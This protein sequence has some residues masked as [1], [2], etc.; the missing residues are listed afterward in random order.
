LQSHAG[1]IHLLPAIPKAWETGSF[2]GL[3]ARGGFELELNWKDGRVQRL[4]ITSATGNPVRILSP[5]NL[6]GPEVN[7]VQTLKGWE[8][9]METTAGSSYV[10]TAG[11]AAPI[12]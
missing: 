2:K 8:I 9:T 11:S 3:K 12:L 1:T 6:T 7:S 10:L 4:M 5:N